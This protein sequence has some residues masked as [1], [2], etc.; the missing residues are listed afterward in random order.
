MYDAHSIPILVVA[1]AACT[2]L[3]DLW[4]G[5]K[6]L[7]RARRLRR[8]LRSAVRRDLAG[9]LDHGFMYGLGPD[10]APLRRP[11]RAA[12]TWPRDAGIA[13][14]AAA[15]REGYRDR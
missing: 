1:L 8:S 12:K 15:Q 10:L 5:I 6:R 9:R 2:L 7:A 4:L 14:A 3:V 13:V 11:A